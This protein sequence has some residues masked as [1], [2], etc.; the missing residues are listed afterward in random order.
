M[1]S[2]LLISKIE[3]TKNMAYEL[4]EISA[5]AVTLTKLENRI[6][7]LA[8]QNRFDRDELRAI[9]EEIRVESIQLA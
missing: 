4:T 3:N 7:T 5:L 6:S 9:V 8:L 2:I 1:L